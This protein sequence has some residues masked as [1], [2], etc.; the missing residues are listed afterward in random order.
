[1]QYGKHSSVVGWVGSQAKLGEHAG[2]V[3]LN[4]GHRHDELGGD[5]PVRSSLGHQREHLALSVRQLVDRV[6]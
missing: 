1:L 3:A 5:E 6:A 2:D 4:R